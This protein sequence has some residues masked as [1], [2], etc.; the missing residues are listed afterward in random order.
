MPYLNS[1]VFYRALPAD[2]ADLVEMPP[3]AMAA[4]TERG[5][6]DAGPLPMAEVLRMG[7][8]LVP[9]GDYCVATKRESVSILLF[10]RVPAEELGGAKIA[11]TDHTSSSVQLLR[12]LFAERWL[13]EPGEYVGLDDE[14]D[15]A[16]VIGDPALRARGDRGGFPHVCDLGTEWYNHTRGLPF[17][18]ARWMARRDAEPG[19]VAE[20]AT[21]LERAYEEGIEA[22][23]DIAG[24][25]PEL[26]MT[27]AEKLIYLEGFSYR[28]G[29]PEYASLE[30]FRKSHSRLPP[31]RPP[32][33]G[34]D[35]TDKSESISA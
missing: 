19:M 6:L 5:E 32:A 17:V 33:P 35:S 11:V 25:R 7:D 24:G 30:R 23:G 27:Q 10:S 3:R 34:S 31:W 2:A 26:G 1:D 13:V 21:A 22:L 29:A 18:Y 9:I 16:L 8:L 14:H 20:F 15:A 28:L 4:A 12:V